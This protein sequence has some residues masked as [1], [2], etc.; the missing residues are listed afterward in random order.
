MWKRGP[1]PTEPTRKG[2]IVSFGLG[3]CQVYAQAALISREI[4]GVHTPKPASHDAFVQNKCLARRD[5]SAAVAR[6]RL[7]FLHQAP[8]ACAILVR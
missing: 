1:V 4:I 5:K 2:R 6:N 3:R 8:K 7:S